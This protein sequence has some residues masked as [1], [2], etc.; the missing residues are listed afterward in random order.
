MNQKIINNKKMKERRFR[1]IY[2]MM[3]RMKMEAKLK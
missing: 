1:I 2:K 3:I